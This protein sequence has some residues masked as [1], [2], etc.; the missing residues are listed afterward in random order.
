M[1]IPKKLLIILSF[2]VMFYGHSVFSEECDTQLFLKCGDENRVWHYHIT[3]NSY[4]LVKSPPNLFSKIE[5]TGR[6][7]CGVRYDKWTEKY[8]EY[9]SVVGE[10]NR[11]T[12][13]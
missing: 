12:G 4:N 5:D 9:I 1:K 13:R 11:T 7:I 6:A 3:A 8:I 10:I 2:N